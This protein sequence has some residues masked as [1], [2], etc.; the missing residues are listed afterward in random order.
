MSSLAPDA[1]E[2]RPKST[3]DLHDSRK[4][5]HR[6]PADDAQGFDYRPESDLF[7]NDGSVANQNL[8][9]ELGYLPPDQRPGIPGELLAHLVD[10]EIDDDTEAGEALRA[11]A[12]VKVGMVGKAAR[13]LNAQS[14]RKL[15]KRATLRGHSGNKRGKPPRI[16]PGITTEASE[17]FDDVEENDD[18]QGSL[19]KV[20]YEDVNIDEVAEIIELPQ[21]RRD[22]Q[23]LDIKNVQVDDTV[24]YELHLLVQRIADLYND[25]PFHNF[26]VRMVMFICLLEL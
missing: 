10:P 3:G 9:I 6:T 21:N 5:D 16:P 22:V 2:T 15:V 12:N 11:N 7:A 18:G 19:F 8:G 26:E 14:V 20:E 17:D 23:E 25:L 1:E 4:F 13:G 24:A